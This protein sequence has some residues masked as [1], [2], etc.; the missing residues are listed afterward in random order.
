M[1]APTVTKDPAGRPMARTEGRR[2]TRRCMQRGRPG[3]DRHETRPL[4]AYLVLHV[5]TWWALF[6]LRVFRSWSFAAFFLVLLQPI[7]LYLLAALVLPETTSDTPF[8]L[9]TN[10]YDHSRWFFGLALTL[11]AV[12]LLRDRRRLR[13]RRWSG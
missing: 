2:V 13:C 5:Q 4:I 12:S 7:I 9:E 1:E 11:L 3:R 8:D 10:C 6:G